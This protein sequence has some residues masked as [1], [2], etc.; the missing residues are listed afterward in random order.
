M[1]SNNH[2]F[3][4]AG[5][6]EAIQDGHQSQHWWCSCHGSEAYHLPQTGMYLSGF[7]QVYMYLSGCWYTGNFF[8]CLFIYFSFFCTVKET[9][10]GVGDQYY[11]VTWKTATKE[12]ENE[13]SDTTPEVLELPSWKA[14]LIRMWGRHYGVA[15][16]FSQHCFMDLYFM[17]TLNSS[18]L[19]F[20]TNI[21]R[22]WLI[23]EP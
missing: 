16:N 7:K 3:C 23:E 14:S 17:A 1:P 22:L 6:E 11:G 12:S 20:D 10:L 15:L 19:C 8:I 4:V 18:T 21:S 2:P 9:D 13:W 5:H